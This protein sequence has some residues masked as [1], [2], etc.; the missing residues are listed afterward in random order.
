MDSVK[1]MI[2][3]VGQYSLSNREQGKS[4]PENV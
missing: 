1:T 3:H 2:L 4:L